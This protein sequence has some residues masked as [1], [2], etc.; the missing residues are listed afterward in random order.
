MYRM[1]QIKAT[2][3]IHTETKPQ[4]SPDRSRTQ[5]ALALSIRARQKQQGMVK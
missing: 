1:P 5:E 4:A 2:P 3:Q